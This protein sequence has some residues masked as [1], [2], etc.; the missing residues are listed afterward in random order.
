[1]QIYL[2]LTSDLSFLH[3]P[4]ELRQRD[5]LLFL[6]TPAAATSASAAVPSASVTAKA[7]T[8]TCLLPL[9]AVVTCES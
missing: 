4:T 1:M 7:S 8:E 9:S 6:F 5:P 2:L 3:Q